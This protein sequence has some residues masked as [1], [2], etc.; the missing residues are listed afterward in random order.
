M[1]SDQFV[2]HFV[3]FLL[4]ILTGAA[5]QY[6]ADKF[7]DQRRRQETARQAHQHFKKIQKQMPKLIEEMKAHL[8]D[9]QM[10]FVRE[11]FTV[12]KSWVLN[13]PEKRFCYYFEDHPDLTGH[14]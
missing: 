14:D 4:G 13:S 7:G 3:A 11:F 9:P 12:N 1:T 2:S 8:Q 5:G 6:F 10:P